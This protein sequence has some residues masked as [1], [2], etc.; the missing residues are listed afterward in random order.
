[1]VHDSREG[2]ENMQEGVY[3]LSVTPNGDDQFEDEEITFRVTDCR[4]N[5]AEPE[6]LIDSDC[7]GFQVCDVDTNLCF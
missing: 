3:T 7:L 2:G 5:K 6:C 4:N 1:M